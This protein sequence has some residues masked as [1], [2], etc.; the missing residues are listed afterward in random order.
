MDPTDGHR[1]SKVERTIANR[2][3][4][5]GVIIPKEGLLEIKKVLEQTRRPSWRSR[6]RS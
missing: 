4:S 3:L 1:L 6:T 2:Q 5:A